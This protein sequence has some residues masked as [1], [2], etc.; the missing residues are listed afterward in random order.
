M[1]F[2]FYG[3]VKGGDC[4]TCGLSSGYLPGQHRRHP[5]VRFLG[6]QFALSQAQ[7]SR[8]YSPFRAQTTCKH[9]ISN[10]RQEY[11]AFEPQAQQHGRLWL[12]FG[13][14]CGDTF[15]LGSR[16]PSRQQRLLSYSMHREHYFPFSFSFSPPLFVPFSG[17]I[18]QFPCLNFYTSQ[19]NAS[20][21]RFPGE[22][23]FV[24]RG[25]FL[26]FRIDVH[27]NVSRSSNFHEK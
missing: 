24:V 23:V 17:E 11:K 2:S 19:R 10:D 20:L 27:Q 9:S 4:C 25:I 6:V 22:S 21:L 1:D 12:R 18:F 7:V 3:Q 13:L 5:S 15:G 14:R 8:K 26:G 16:H